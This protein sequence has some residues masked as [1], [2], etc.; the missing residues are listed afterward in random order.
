MVA[1]ATLAEFALDAPAPDGPTTASDPEPLRALHTSNLSALLRQLGAS[2]LVTAYQ[3]G[4]IVM[5]RDE[6]GRLNTHF[7]SFQGPM[8]L[9]AAGLVGGHRNHC[10]QLSPAS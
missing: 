8:G 9:A 7:R 5:V 6:G 2:L 1:E 3:A 10:A 4:K